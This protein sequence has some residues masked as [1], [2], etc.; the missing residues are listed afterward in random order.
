MREAASAAYQKLS[1]AGVDSQHNLAWKYFCPPQT[2][3]SSPS[4][5]SCA[6][7]QLHL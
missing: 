2:I 5:C 6:A 4:T 3:S 1:C 7:I